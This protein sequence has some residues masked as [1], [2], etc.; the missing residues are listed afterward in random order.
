SL[1][2]GLQGPRAREAF[3]GGGVLGGAPRRRHEGAGRHDD[4]EQTC[5]DSARHSGINFHVSS[6]P[7]I[8]TIPAYRSAPFR[9]QN[10][11]SLSPRPRTPLAATAAHLLSS[12][13]GHPR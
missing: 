3:L 11:R 8:K 6:S 12:S 2:G 9:T 13:S 1:D 10:S 7:E 5:C 4:Q